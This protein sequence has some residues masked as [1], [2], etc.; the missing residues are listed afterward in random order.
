MCNHH[1]NVNTRTSLLFADLQYSWWREIHFCCH[2]FAMQHGSNYLTELCPIK[3]DV[4]L[5]E[6]VASCV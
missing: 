3:E 4:L 2:V 6:E 5:S 1:I